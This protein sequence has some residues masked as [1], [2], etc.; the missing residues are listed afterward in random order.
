[1]GLSKVRMIKL[2][3][4]NRMITEVPRKVREIRTY[5]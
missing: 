4:G 3:Y 1:M 2:P 5:M